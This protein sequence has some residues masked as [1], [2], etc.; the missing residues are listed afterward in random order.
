APAFLGGHK[1]GMLD[2]LTIKVGH[3]KGAVRTRGEIHGMKPRIGGSEKLF[4]LLATLRHEG[5]AVRLQDAAMDQIAEGFTNK[6]VPVIGGPEGVAAV[7]GQAGQGIE[8]AGGFVVKSEGRWGE[9]KD[10][11]GITPSQDVE[12][13][14]RAREIRI[15]A[16]VAFRQH[17]MPK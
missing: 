3:I 8:M 7:E 13:G 15:A 9:R 12:H 2:P 6:G 16:E 1:I 14:L 5:D 4:A 17:F 10:P 11:A